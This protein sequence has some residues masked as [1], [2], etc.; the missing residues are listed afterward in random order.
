MP[1]PLKNH[2]R[3][4][5]VQ[6]LI[7]GEAMGDAYVAAGYKRNDKNAA[8][9]RSNPEVAARIAELQEKAAERAV[10]TVESITSRLLKIAEKGEAKEDASL[11]QVARAS[12]MDAAKLNGLVIDR[13]KFGLDL[14][15]AT[16]EELEILERF[17]ARSPPRA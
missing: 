6:A 14:T 9:L 3:E 13:S 8:R 5:F 1:G 11:L 16:D 12:L 7:K 17:F 15:N 10:I 4:R 2:Q